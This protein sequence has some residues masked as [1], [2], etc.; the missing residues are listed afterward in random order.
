MKLKLVIL[1]HGFQYEN[2]TE[3]QLSNAMEEWSSENDLESVVVERAFLE[4]KRDFYPCCG[5]QFKESGYKYLFDEIVKGSL[6]D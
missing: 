6:L 4:S 5:I 1:N 3:D 2:W